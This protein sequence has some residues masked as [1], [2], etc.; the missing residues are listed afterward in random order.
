VIGAPQQSHGYLS[1]SLQTD[2]ESAR[3]SNVQPYKFNTQQQQ[4]PKRNGPNPNAMQIRKINPNSVVLKPVSRGSG[5]GAGLQS[6]SSNPNNMISP[7][8]NHTVPGNDRLEYLSNGASVMSAGSGLPDLKKVLNTT[9][10][11]G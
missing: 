7:L 1:G 2:T 4:Q 6:R 5:V 9:L 11:A 8:V 3:L 10:D